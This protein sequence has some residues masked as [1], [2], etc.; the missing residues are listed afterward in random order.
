MPLDRSFFHQNRASTERIAALVARLS[1]A[2]LLRPVGAHWTVA[3]TLAHLAFWDRRVQDVL[4]QSERAG[5]VVLPQI[6][7]VVN[8]LALPFWAAIPPRTAATLALS[9]AETLDARLEDYPAALLEAIYAR[10]ERLV[11]RALH[12]NEHLDEVDQA[13]AT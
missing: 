1:D 3:V 8:D 11:V 5:S 10:S 6:D 12:R 7:F 4:D 9:T 13:L 2:D